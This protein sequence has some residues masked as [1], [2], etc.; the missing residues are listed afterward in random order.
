MALKL[1]IGIQ[2]GMR[3]GIQI[4]QILGLAESS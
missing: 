2:I 3:I 4:N 1:T